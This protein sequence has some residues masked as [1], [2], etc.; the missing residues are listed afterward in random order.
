M[1]ELYWKSFSE[2]IY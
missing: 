2:W 1:R